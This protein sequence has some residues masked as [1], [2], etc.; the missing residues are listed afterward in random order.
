MGRQVGGEGG[1]VKGIDEMC[2]G[3][4]KRLTEEDER[5]GR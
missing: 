3:G 1:E 5:G 2:R 4:R